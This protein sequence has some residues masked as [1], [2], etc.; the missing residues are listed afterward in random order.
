M[1]KFH[2]VQ[3]ALHYQGGVRMDAQGGGWSGLITSVG[4]Y[5]PQYL[6]K[7]FNTQFRGLQQHI[8]LFKG[9]WAGTAFCA[10]H[11][12]A[13]LHSPTSVAQSWCAPE[14]ATPGA[15]LCVRPT[16][17]PATT[18]PPPPIAAPTRWPFSLARLLSQAVLLCSVR[19]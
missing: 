14:R 8:I 9:L 16:G 15:G 3:A 11:Q 18:P 6:L 12:H 1:F 2:S 7:Q 13:H 19:D 5:P 17:T 10:P 4:F